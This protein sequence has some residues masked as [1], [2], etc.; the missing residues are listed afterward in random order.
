[1]ELEFVEYIRRQREWSEKTFGLGRRTKGITDHIRS[2][3]LEVESTPDDPY[4]WVDIVILALDGAW[5]TGASLVEIRRLLWDKQKVNFER[6][7]PYPESED[8]MS[9]H[10]KE[11]KDGMDFR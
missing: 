6:K 9:E 1:M 10:I 11:D 4:E 8:H 3:L 5:R 7:F 2:E